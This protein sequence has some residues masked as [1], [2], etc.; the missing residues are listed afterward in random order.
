MY[1]IM[2]ALISRQVSGQAI[3]HSPNLYKIPSTIQPQSE[4]FQDKFGARPQAKHIVKTIGWIQQAELT[5]V[6]TPYQC[7]INIIMFDLDD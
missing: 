6:S 5:S 2:T 4:S 3:L 1:D 7:N